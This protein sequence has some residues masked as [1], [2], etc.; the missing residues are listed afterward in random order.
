MA[1]S[2]HAA[3]AHKAEKCHLR[4]PLMLFDWEVCRLQQRFY[5]LPANYKPRLEHKQ[6]AGLNAEAGETCTHPHT[7]TQHT[8]TETRSD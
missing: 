4:G 5:N 1:Q 8:R 2:H 7:L 3:Q 6:A